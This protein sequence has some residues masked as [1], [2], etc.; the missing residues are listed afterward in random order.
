MKLFLKIA[1]GLEVGKFQEAEQGNKNMAEAFM[2]I[3]DIET[4]RLLLRNE[5]W[6][7]RSRKLNWVMKNY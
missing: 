7:T 3:N 2:K 6:N 5:L 4:S 1:I